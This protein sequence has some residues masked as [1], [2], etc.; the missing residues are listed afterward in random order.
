MGF[1]NYRSYIPW[2]Y[3]E[4]FLSPLAIAACSLIFLHHSTIIVFG[5][6]VHRLAITDLAIVG[7]ETCVLCYV[8]HQIAS[9]LFSLSGPIVCILTI[10]AVMLLLSAAFRIATLFA[11]NDKLV[12][13]RF[14]F[15]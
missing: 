7:I 10:Q 2:V 5:W 11:C 1:T 8:L 3:F 12:N 13:Q 14:A 4:I 6:R 15:L 9:E